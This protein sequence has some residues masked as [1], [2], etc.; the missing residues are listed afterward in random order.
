[1][2]QSPRHVTRVR[3]FWCARVEKG[4]T[5]YSIIFLVFGWLFVTAGLWRE[6]NQR[7]NSALSL[8]LSL[9]HTHQNTHTFDRRRRACEQLNSETIKHRS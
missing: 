7:P 6:E 2:I 8:S 5:F 1:M 3:F 9:S 4:N